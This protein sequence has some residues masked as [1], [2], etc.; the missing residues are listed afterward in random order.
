MTFSAA[1]FKSGEAGFQTRENAPVYKFRAL[2]LVAYGFVSGHDFSR[3][4]QVQTDSGFSCM[5][6]IAKH[7][8]AKAA[9]VGRC[10]LKF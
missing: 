1:S 9:S 3:A 8:P 7:Q 2:A 6:P 5:N 10:K 4:A